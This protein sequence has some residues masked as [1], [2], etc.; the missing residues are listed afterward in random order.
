M[1]PANN[2]SLSEDAQK[3]IAL[4]QIKEMLDSGMEL[5]IRKSSDDSRYLVAVKYQKNI[6]A[7]SSFDDLLHGIDWVYTRCANS[8][9]LD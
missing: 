5:E 6:C 9:M 8:N 1:T 2:Y 7:A 4:D 3:T